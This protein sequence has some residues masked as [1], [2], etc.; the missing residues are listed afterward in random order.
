MWFGGGLEVVRKQE[1]SELPVWAKVGAA[2]RLYGLQYIN[3]K[4][5][6]L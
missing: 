5:Q 4:S 2:V 3:L 6:L 1:M